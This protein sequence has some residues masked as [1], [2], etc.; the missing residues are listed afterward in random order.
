MPL[1]V[2]FDLFPF[3]LP[4]AFQAV[5]RMQDAVVL[6][7]RGNETR[8]S[9]VAHRALESHIIGLGAAR[10]K[11]YLTDRCAQIMGH[12]FA[13]LLDGC[14]GGTA[15]GVDGR[16][17]SKIIP[18]GLRHRF[19]HLLRQGGGGGVVKVDAFHDFFLCSYNNSLLNQP[20]TSW[21]S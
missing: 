19:N 3:D 18:H 12:L 13:G 21:V 8:H 4:E 20:S 7:R 16:G 6:Y 9:Q 10:G 1:S 15:F 11:E 2:Q 14:P 17:V 5:Q